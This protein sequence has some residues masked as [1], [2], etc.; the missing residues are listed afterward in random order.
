MIKVAVTDDHQMII[1]GLKI[2]LRQE[3]EIVLNSAY[4]SLKQMCMEIKDHVPDVLLLDISLPDGYSM[5]TC[6]HLLIDYPQMKIIV[7]TNLLEPEYVIQMLKNGAHSYLLKNTEKNELINAIKIVAGGTNYLPDNI[8]QLLLHQSISKKINAKFSTPDLSQR[9]KEILQLI[10]QEFTTEEISGHLHLSHKTVEVHRSN[11][12]Q[13]L[14]VKNVAGLVRV[15]IEKNWF[16]TIVKTL[17][18]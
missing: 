5:D 13:K 4:K 8:K 10:V 2:M 9:E 15:A 16:E 6:K 11:L 3:P 12:L 17:K 14:D 7:L 18:K 1:E